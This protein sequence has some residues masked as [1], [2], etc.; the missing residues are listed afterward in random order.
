MN[1]SQNITN[2]TLTFDTESGLNMMELSVAPSRDLLG[3]SGLRRELSPVTLPG[4][5][6]W[7][8]EAGVDHLVAR[9]LRAP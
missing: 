8:R 5:I 2:I 4:N 7:G 9:A 3:V 1:Q 6:I